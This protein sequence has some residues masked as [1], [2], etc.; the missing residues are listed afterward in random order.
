MRF[1][2]LF[3]ELKGQDMRHTMTLCGVLLALTLAV[4]WQTGDHQFI[5][6]DD[7]LYVTN[8]PHVKGGVTGGNVA[9]AFT[10]THASNWH[11]LTWLS[12]MADVDLFGLNPRGHH[13]VS[14]FIHAASTL[15]LFLLLVRMTRAAWQSLFVAAL[16]ALHPLHVESIA[17][18]AERK[19][20]LSGFFWF[21]TLF[22]YAGYVKRPRF[23]FYLLALVSY[24]LGLMTKPM[25]V[26][27][28]IVMLLTD[29]WPFGRFPSTQREGGAVTSS[30]LS[31]LIKE[32]LPFCFFCGFSAAVT[33]YAQNKGEALKSLEAIPLLLRS[34][35]AVI[36]YAKYL[37]KTIWPN[38]LAI[39]YPFPVSVPLS[40]V[41]GSSLLVVLI[42]AVA[43]QYRRRCPYLLVG[44]F[45]FLVS[46]VPVI[47]LVQVGGQSMADR[48]TYIPL[49]GL[50]LVCAWG[51]SDLLRGW[52][53]RRTILLS[54]AVLA[55][56][57]LTVV[58]WHQIG[59]WK[60]NISLYQ[61]ALQVTA[62][63]YVIHNNFGIAL[64]DQG[65]SDEAILEYRKAIQAWPKAAVAHVTLGAA[66]AN[67]GD[68]V[69]AIDHYN[70]ALRLIPDY[71]LAHANLGRALVKLGRIGEA[72]THYEETLKI[73]PAFADVH[74][75]L[76]IILLKQQELD[77]AFHHYDI[78]LRLEPYSAKGPINMGAA[79]AQEGRAT[80]AAQCFADALRIDPGSVEAHFNLGIILAR[81]NRR[82]EALNHFSEV[83]KIR[84]DLEA[85]RRWIETLKLQQ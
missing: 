17:W 9:W 39:F 29:Y 68:L 45:W 4:F 63:N 57:P 64:A 72:I 36:A 79:L 20:V 83:L 33:M 7:P 52:P 85:A 31:S 48:Y 16:F 44:W 26:T 41:I 10:T 23:K 34:E 28:P 59:Y 81:Q 76:A 40:Q 15:L 67:R 55:V 19:D 60:D 37:G 11:P 18:V 56:F 12:H 13:L 6:F 54:L 46:L 47:G 66:L 77:R 84:P 70:E 3:G 74:L 75:N 43:I 32:K 35:N 14:V 42:S 38:D 25:L 71:A 53:Y 50:F 73:D 78:F 30:S 69:E 49:T 21:L 61:H 22:F 80:E 58:T 5:N 2:V 27:L 62:S 65:R 1:A 82:E 8:N 51:I 24:V